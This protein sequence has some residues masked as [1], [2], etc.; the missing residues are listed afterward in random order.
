MD[1]NSSGPERSGALIAALVLGGLLLIGS[2]ISAIP[3]VAGYFTGYW[4]GHGDLLTGREPSIGV[5]G[6]TTE[7]D[8]IDYSGIVIVSDQSLMLPRVLQAIAEGLGILVIV[9]GGA[10]AVM[11]AVRMLRGRPFVR[12]LAWGLGV[13]GVLTVLAG[14]V[15]PQLRAWAVDAAV[16]ELGYA[17]S[18]GTDGTLTAD[19][20]ELIVLPQWDVL[21]I[22]DRVDVTL[23]LLGVIIAILGLLVADGVRLQRDTDG[24]I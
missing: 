19:G 4:N 1:A 24:L 20:P 8:R 6:P 17:V 3:R 12:M 14:A 23:L 13:V 9:A 10:L 11:L 21:W 2:A 16:R 15:A 18:E 7:A 5:A 22:L